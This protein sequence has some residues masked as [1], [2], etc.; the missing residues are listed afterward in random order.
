VLFRGIIWSRILQWS[1]RALKQFG[2]KCCQ[3]YFYHQ[4]D[5]GRQKSLDAAVVAAVW[6]DQAVEPR[7][8]EGCFL[9]H[10]ETNFIAEVQTKAMPSIINNI[11]TAITV[12]FRRFA[13]CPRDIPLDS[14]RMGLGESG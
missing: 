11:F 1:G 6:F 14:I 12:A 5:A 10:D 4:E 13:S 3:S 9:P 8:L 7:M 2:S